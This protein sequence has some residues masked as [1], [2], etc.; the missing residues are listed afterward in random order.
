MKVLQAGQIAVRSLVPDCS[1]FSYPEGKVSAQQQ[2]ALEGHLSS[3]WESFKASKSTWHLE[4]GFM[5]HVVSGERPNV[6]LVSS[7]SYDMCFLVAGETIS[8]I[9]TSFTTDENEIRQRA[10]VHC[11]NQEAAVRRLAR[12]INSTKDAVAT[13]P[14]KMEVPSLSLEESEKPP[15]L[16]L[17]TAT[18]RSRK[19]VIKTEPVSGKRKVRVLIF[20]IVN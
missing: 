13:T 16:S 19:S 7:C 4:T 1:Q 5:P 2:K 8:S 15:L 14:V 18:T 20:L 3:R 12:P 6:L 9:V 11:S 17:S 10:V